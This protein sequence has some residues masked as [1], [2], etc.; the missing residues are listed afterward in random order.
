MLEKS[1]DILLK[2]HFKRSKVRDHLKN[3]E[4][5]LA[6]NE[7]ERWLKSSAITFIFVFYWASDFH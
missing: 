4:L 7:F 3:K 6:Y 1:R 2:K 5:T